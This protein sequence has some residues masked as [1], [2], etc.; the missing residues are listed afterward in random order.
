VAL[1]T[2]LQRL[3]PTS[4]QE[5]HQQ[6]LYRVEARQFV[7]RI[8]AIF[9][10]WLSLREVEFDNSALANAAAVSRWELMRMA[11]SLEHL[12][13]PRSLTGIHRAVE[14]ALLTSARACQLLAN[15]YRNHKA[16]VVCDGQ[17]MLLEMVTEVN[18]LLG[19]LQ[20]RA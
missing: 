9:E 12:S 10:R 3:R 14:S 11:G 2:F 13:P 15:G 17:A 4:D 7:T 19:R 8:Q 16:E 1:A 20:M 5:Q 18:G 6:H